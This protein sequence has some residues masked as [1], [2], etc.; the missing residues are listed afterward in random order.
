MTDD[1]KDDGLEAFFA[2]ARGRNDRPSGALVAR[3]LADAEAEQPARGGF[4][5]FFRALGGWPSA[6]GLVAASAA[7]VLIGFNAP[8]AVLLF[9]AGATESAYDLTDLVPGYGTPMAFD[10]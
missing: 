2:E 9:D 1:L 3:V 10:G 5:G 8:D 7:G 6:A 4:A